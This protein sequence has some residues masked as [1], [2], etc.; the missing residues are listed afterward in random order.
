[1]AAAAVVG[2]KVSKVVA[3]N[4]RMQSR[5]QLAVV[6]LVQSAFETRSRGVG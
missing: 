4:R 6:I 3:S 5:V 1:V 2:E